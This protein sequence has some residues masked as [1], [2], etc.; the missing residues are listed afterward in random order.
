MSALV[1]LTGNRYGKLTVLY[2]VPSVNRNSSWACKCDC[3]KQTIVQAPNL[4]SGSTR[5]CGCGVVESTIRRSTKHGG[6]RTKLH[7]VWEGMKQRCNNPNNKQ[8]EDYGGRGISICEEWN[9]DFGA[10]RDWAMA[11]G[12]KEGLTIERMNNDGNYCPENCK[13]ATYLEQSRNRRPRRWAKKP[14]RKEG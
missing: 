11:N 6:S 13:W 2:Q 10:F 3:G 4:K 14:I 8:F 1:D 9:N 12:Y 5:T 7:M